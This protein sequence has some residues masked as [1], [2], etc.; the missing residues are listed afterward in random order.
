VI[1]RAATRL[2]E[3]PRYGPD[4]AGLGPAIDALGGEVVR[5]ISRDGVRLA[6]RWLPAEVPGY[7]DAVEAA[8]AGPAAAEAGAGEAETGAI[9]ADTAAAAAEP[10]R[11][12]PYEAILLLHG[13]TGS[14]AP[15]LVALGPTL[16]RTAGVLGLDF[17]GHGGSDDGLTTFGLREIEDVAGALVWFAERGIRR[18]ALVGSSMGGAVAIAAIV[19]LGDGSLPSADLDP[20]RPAATVGPPPP[21]IV[22]AVVES[23]A[24]D[25]RIPIANRLGLPI[26][27]PL[28]RALAGRAFDAA[29]RRVGGDLRALEP[30]RVI[31]LVE[32]VPLLLIHGA[33]DRT[34]RAR[35]GQRLAAL[36]GPSAEHW[37]VPG[38]DHGAARAAAPGEW[39]RRVSRFL[40][41]AFVGAREAE[42][43]I[44]AP[45]DPA[46]ASGERGQ[47]GD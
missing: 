28:R 10:W 12:D 47:E 25:L 29:S 5:L 16:R 24:P 34:V 27:G 13:W 3:A 36:A 4:E 38:A 17:R 32:P 40:R 46:G 35:D 45:V 26:G 39:D 31:R 33:A 41:R 21:R 1:G 42:P 18:V 14:V 30:G 15:D 11:P 22:G 19:A 9:A 20:E 43:I 44:A 6:G 8:E 23:V 2:L 37:I 7:A